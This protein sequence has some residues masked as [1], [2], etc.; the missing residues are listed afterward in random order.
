M[1]NQIY[2]VRWYEDYDKMTENENMSQVRG[3]LISFT[4]TVYKKTYNAQRSSS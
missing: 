1:K 2:K 3:K 4:Q